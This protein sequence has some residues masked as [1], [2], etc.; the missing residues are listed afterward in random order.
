MTKAR[1]ETCDRVGGKTTGK[2]AIHVSD[3]EKFVQ[4]TAYG[5]HTV[6]RERGQKPRDWNFG[7]RERKEVD[8]T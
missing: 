2:G 6:L 4:R 1:R 7:W 5:R 3:T 8:L